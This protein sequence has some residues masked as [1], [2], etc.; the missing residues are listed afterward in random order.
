[1]V[2][3][4]PPYGSLLWLATVDFDN[5]I[6]QRSATLPEVRDAGGE[7]GVFSYRRF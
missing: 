6:R 4:H 2:G 5:A 1:M 7:N 3:W